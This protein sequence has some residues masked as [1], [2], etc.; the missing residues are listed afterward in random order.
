M[1]A[2]KLTDNNNQNIDKEAR[3]GKAELLDNVTH[4]DLLIDPSIS[5][6]QQTENCVLAFPTEFADLQREYPILLQFNP[7]TKQYQAVILLG[8]ERGENL[9]FEHNQWQARYIPASIAKGPFS[10]G[11]QKDKNDAS[12]PPKP[13]VMINPDDPCVNQ[14][15]G[16]AIFKEFGGN[17]AY[18]EKINQ[19]LNMILHGIEQASVMYQ[20]FEQLEL[21][22]PLSLEITLNSG[23]THKINGFHTI[24]RDK[25]MQLSAQQTHQLNQQ[26]LLEGAYLIINSLNN[27]QRLIDAKNN[28]NS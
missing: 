13:M 4:A 2:F 26:G 28:K 24:S 12:A 8:I 6:S 7:Q 22:E 27:I 23:V 16:Q 9:Y 20:T 25:L 17:S 19:I 14:Q 15:Q 1:A 11:L 18:L 3:M 5:L 10:I 21:I